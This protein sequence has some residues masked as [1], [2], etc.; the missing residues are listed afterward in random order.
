[1]EGIEIVL[2]GVT[3][4]VHNTLE[5]A[6]FYQYVPKENICSHINIALERAKE[7]LQ[8][9]GLTPSDQRER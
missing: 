8:T 5:H 1:N 7:M 9:N 2:S 3:E 4:K 6:G